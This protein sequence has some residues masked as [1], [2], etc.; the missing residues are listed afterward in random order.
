MFNRKKANVSN[1]FFSVSLTKG[2]MM[3][4]KNGKLCIISLWFFTFKLK[5]YSNQF[6]Y[7]TI[8]WN[9]S[10]FHSNSAFC[11]TQE[12]KYIFR[13]R[14]ILRVIVH[15]KEIIKFQEFEQFSCIKVF[16]YGSESKIT[17]IKNIEWMTFFWVKPLKN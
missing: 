10:I 7:H 4:V 9:S 11:K 15:L 13:M 12:M 16:P 2:K 14:K 17:V 8:T 3:K 1:M 6:F 5:T